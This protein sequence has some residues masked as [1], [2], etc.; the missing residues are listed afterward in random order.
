MDK[1][2]MLELKEL[3]A[4]TNIDF[5]RK[6]EENNNIKIGFSKSIDITKRNNPELKEYFK[7]QLDFL[8]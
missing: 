4:E 8:K 1:K 2:I 7:R 3:I 5:L 6:I